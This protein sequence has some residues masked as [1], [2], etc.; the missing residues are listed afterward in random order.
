M[1][2]RNETCLIRG[3]E[4][5]RHNASQFEG[6]GRSICSVAVACSRKRGPAHGRCKTETGTRRDARTTAFAGIGFRWRVLAIRKV[7]ATWADRDRAV[8]STLPWKRP[9][10]KRRKRSS[11]RCLTLNEQ[12]KT[13]GVFHVFF[14]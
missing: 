3:E 7:N 13:Y 5:S 4:Q 9:R 2:I 11:R 6:N 12:Q 8:N 10:D 1:Y 14:F